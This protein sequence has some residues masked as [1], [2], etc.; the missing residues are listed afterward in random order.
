VAKK[1]A[2]K[3]EKVEK[4]EKEDQE[5]EVKKVVKKEEKKD[6][7]KE[8]NKDDKE[9]DKKADKAESISIATKQKAEEGKAAIDDEDWVQ[10]DGSEIPKNASVED[11][12]EEK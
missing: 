6:V 4:D 5:K 8:V 3:V 11:A 12:E 7:K 9:T 2:K 10:I 1:E